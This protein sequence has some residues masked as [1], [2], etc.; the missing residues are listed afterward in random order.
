M[1]VQMAVVAPEPARQD[2]Q[3]ELVAVPAVPP[4]AVHSERVSPVDQLA[5]GID[6]AGI[7]AWHENGL[8]T[9]SH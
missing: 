7:V 3:V 2:I 1:F 8:G 5:Y 9:K 4:I 6:G